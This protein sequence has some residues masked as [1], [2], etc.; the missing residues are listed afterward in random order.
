MS[1]DESQT[2]EDETNDDERSVF[3]DS[4]DSLKEAFESLLRNVYLKKDYVKSKNR[5][6]KSKDEIDSLLIKVRARNAFENAKVA[7][8]KKLGRSYHAKDY[9]NLPE[10]LWRLYKHAKS[11]G[12][13]SYTKSTWS[14]RTDQDDEKEYLYRNR[15]GSTNLPDDHHKMIPLED[16]YQFLMEVHLRHG[17]MGATGMKEYLTRNKVGCFPRDLINKF[18]NFCHHCLEKK[19]EREL[20][21]KN[22]PKDHVMIRSVDFG[23]LILVSF[24]I[25]VPEILNETQNVVLGL[26]EKSN[27]AFCFPIGN[28]YDMS[29]YAAK[30]MNA[31]MHTGIPNLIHLHD[32]SAE[33][34][35]EVSLYDQ[36][37]NLKKQCTK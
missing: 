4:P 20:L 1:D 23:L 2:N 14:I 17:H 24:S 29:S 13:F 12:G 28:T 3:S 33:Q 19:K 5:G 16:S 36:C 22:K 7:S 35:A 26:F 34:S 18:H 6:W 11:N 15:S 31:L 32:C 25:V 27:Y 8:E 37:Y 10:D 21:R 30:V 9:I